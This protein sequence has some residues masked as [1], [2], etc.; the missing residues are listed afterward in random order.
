M[1]AFLM[2]DKM[3]SSERSEPAASEKIFEK[4]RLWEEDY[5]MQVGLCAYCLSN[6]IFL[7]PYFLPLLSWKYANENMI[8]VP[9]YCFPARRLRPCFTGVDASVSD[10]HFT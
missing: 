8:Y 10:M 6:L 9:P 2:E 3:E 1:L 5:I 7:P 4:V